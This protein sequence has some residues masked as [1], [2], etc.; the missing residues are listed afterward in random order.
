MAGRLVFGQTTSPCFEE[1]T[2]F[3]DFTFFSD[4]TN[5]LRN[6]HVNKSSMRFSVQVQ[7]HER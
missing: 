5:F 6:G 7:P 2:D 4:E 3:L 1:N